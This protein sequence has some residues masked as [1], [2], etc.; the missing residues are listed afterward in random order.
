MAAEARASVVS[1]FTIIKGSMIE[2]T[3]VVFRNWDFDQ[4]REQN[5]AAMKETNSIGATSANWLRDVYKVLHRRFEPNGRDRALVELAKHGSSYDV[6]KPVLLWH[7]TRDEFLV[8]DFLSNWLFPLYQEGAL[9]VRVEELLPY[10]EGLHTKGLTEAPW[11]K[12]TMS[13]VASGLLRMAVDFGLMSG[14]LA[15]EFSSY[16]MPE[17]AFIYL[18]HAMSEVQPNAHAVVHSPDWRMFLMDTTDVERELFR[19]H[20]Y[21]RVH[22]EVAGTLAQLTLPCASARDFVEE[23]AS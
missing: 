22:Y 6:F 13:R 16:H 1:S 8:R 11:K 4:T 3:Y 5:L 2:E 23:L 17:E 10:L 14:T 15:R 7:M 12:T 21:R 9:R 20:Q 19:L 18:L